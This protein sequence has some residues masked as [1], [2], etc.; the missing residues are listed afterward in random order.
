MEN[1]RPSCFRL[2]C[3]L[4][5]L[6]PPA[7]GAAWVSGSG[8]HHFGPDSAENEACALAEE[9]AKIDALR[10]FS[11]ESLAL[12][13]HLACREPGEA[14]A[15]GD[16]C[17]YNRMLW[18]QVGGRI[19]AVGGVRR[20]VL[21]RPGGKL[22]R[23]GLVADIAVPPG[24]PDPAFDLGVRLNELAFR[25][26]ERLQ[27]E[28]EPSQAMYL[29]VFNWL[30][31]Q[32]A[33]RQVVRIFPNRHEGDPL[34]RGK[35]T[36]PDPA[37]RFELTLPEGTAQRRPFVDEYLLVV[38]TKEAV[39]WRESYSLDELQERLHEIPLDR[40]RY[41]KRAYHLIIPQREA[42]KRSGK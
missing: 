36:I 38:A 19:G 6:L 9:N 4:L 29:A 23:V 16:R 33:G 35:R 2:A 26:G 21:E 18:S 13:Q 17:S 37:Y 20:E 42:Q 28:I 39:N 12:D 3:L 1:R 41:V 10:S 8:E 31:H 34:I 15:A 22:C 24:R 11:G 27:I 7:A 25:P 40:M 5:A 32:P 30:P 14:E